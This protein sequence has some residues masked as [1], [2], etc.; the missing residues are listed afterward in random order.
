MS[1]L[2]SVPSLRCLVFGK[3]SKSE[4]HH[5]PHHGSS[6][7]SANAS[8]GHSSKAEKCRTR[9]GCGGRAEI[10]RNFSTK[11]LIVNGNAAG[12]AGGSSVGAA[13]DHAKAR[14]G[15]DLA[16]P[17]P[18]R[19]CETVN[20][21]IPHHNNGL[22]G[23][24]HGR[25]RSLRHPS[26]LSLF[27]R[28]A[29]RKGGEE[30]RGKRGHNNGTALGLRTP[31]GTRSYFSGS[32]CESPFRV[33]VPYSPLVLPMYALRFD[34]AIT[35]SLL[36]PGQVSCPFTLPHP[37]FKQGIRPVNRLRCSTSSVMCSRCASICVSYSNSRMTSRAPSQN[38]LQMRRASTSTTLQVVGFVFMV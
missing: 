32:G 24:D 1:D 14:G 5:S 20:G 22:C 17:A 13:G 9:R 38:S 33:R 6:L 3:H 2:S 23:G 25:H 21:L 31:Q 10:Q 12:S 30:E 26:S 11:S 18:I 15:N 34:F 16:S 35:L 8:R 37:L 28:L 4:Q 7:G 29:M 36:D 19:K 27:R